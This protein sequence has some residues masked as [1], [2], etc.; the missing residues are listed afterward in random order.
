MKTENKI[1]Y[2]CLLFVVRLFFLNRFISFIHRAI[3][4]LTLYICT[5]TSSIY[6]AVY[7][8]QIGKAEMIKKLGTL[9]GI[10]HNQIHDMFLLGP[11]EI[12]VL[13]TDEVVGNIK[14]ESMFSIE[15]FKG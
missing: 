12:K 15:V 2:C 1:C 13:I 5:P 4:R 3:V 10:H 7:L 8:D 9:L 6:Y 11:N 14:D